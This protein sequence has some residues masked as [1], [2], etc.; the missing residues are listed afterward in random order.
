VRT[1]SASY[2]WG[3]WIAQCPE[4][5]CTD[6]RAVYHPQTGQRQSEDV[7]A[8]GHPFRIEMPPPQ[9]EAQI[10]AVLAERARDA[11]KAWYPKGHAWATLAGF[12]T[13]QSPQELAEEGR[14]VATFRAAEKEREQEHLRELLTGLGIQVHPDGRVEGNI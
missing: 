5:G 2:D 11:D 3:R 6:A 12:P 13:G 4:P 7:C 1:A 14:H 10:V 8:N 9:L